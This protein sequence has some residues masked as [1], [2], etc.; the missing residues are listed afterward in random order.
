MAETVEMMGDQDMKKLVD[1]EVKKIFQS[2]VCKHILCNQEL[3]NVS[4]CYILRT[5]DIENRTVVWI[6]RYVNTV[7]M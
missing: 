1:Q 5:V 4:S 7:M 2:S 3:A 6:L